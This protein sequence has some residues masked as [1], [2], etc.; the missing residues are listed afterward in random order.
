MQSD[1]IA[2]KFTH[3]SS[4]SSQGK[5]DESI[6]FIAPYLSYDLENKDLLTNMFY[7]M[8]HNYWKT[9]RYEEAKLYYS[10]AQSILKENGIYKKL[11]P[12]VNSLGLYQRKSGN[13]RDALICFLEGLLYAF[14]YDDKRAMIAITANIA[15]VMIEMRDYERSERGYDAALKLCLQVPNTVDNS[16]FKCQIL[17]NKCLLSFYQGKPSQ[18]K[19]ILAQ[20]GTMIDNE[21]LGI[22]RYDI[23]TFM[24]HTYVRIG[25]HDMAYRLLK[26]KNLSD[27][28]VINLPH[29]MNLISMGAVSWSLY[30]DEGSFLKYLQQALDFSET[31][32]IYPTKLVAHEALHQHYLA[33]GDAT[34]AASHEMKYKTLQEDKRRE[35]EIGYLTSILE[36][37]MEAIEDKT[38][39]NEKI[40]NLL[41]EH[42][43]LIN[44]YSYQYHRINYQVPL[45]DIVYVEVQKNYLL[46]YTVADPDINKFKMVHVHTVR[47]ALKDFMAEIS[48]AASY[49]VRV[50][51]SFIVNLYWISKFPQKSLTRLTIGDKELPVSVTYR[52]DFRNNMNAFLRNFSQGT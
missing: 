32:D 29:V 1:E 25:E 47:K 10:K 33:L 26:D 51:G 23:E 46:I 18:I 42:D 22:H 44:S 2:H 19:G 28:S 52:S 37:N 3:A 35:Q 16:L 5:F 21:D 34:L 43:F 36:A 7:L 39:I 6:E 50:H 17:L 15:L 13:Y 24:I 40:G 38:R 31:H 11:P 41:S 48:S 4:L 9:G 27:A 14:Q 8:G 49:F 45:R 12:V 20:I 30:H